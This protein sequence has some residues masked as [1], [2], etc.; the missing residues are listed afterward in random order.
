MSME[1]RKPFVRTS[2]FN[3]YLED[4]QATAISVDYTGQWMLVKFKI[5][6]LISFQ[7][8]IYLS[9]FIN[10]LAGR[11]HL[12][13]QNLNNFNDEVKKF[14]RN[15]KYEV[16]CAEFAICDLFKSHW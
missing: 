10:Q 16:S 3:R 14:Y 1:S 13:L 5:I 6:H 7:L 11:R 2:E 9:I 12:A 4:L 15:S 8:F